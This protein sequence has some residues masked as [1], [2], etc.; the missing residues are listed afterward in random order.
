MAAL[1][2][3][4]PTGCTG[5]RNW[6]NC[7]V[8]MVELP[9]TPTGILGPMSFNTLAPY[10]HG[11]EILFAGRLMQRSRTAFL[12]KA[13]SCQ[14]ALLV[15]EGPGCFLSALL[16]ANPHVQ[17]T[18][19]EH[20]AGM[21]RQARWHLN[22]NRLDEKRVVFV[23]Q[24]A[25]TWSCPST[26]FDLL[27][28]HF[29]LDCFPAEQLDPLVRQL[30]KAATH[31]ASWLLADFQMPPDGWHRYRALTITALLY[32]FF[33]CATGIAASRLTPPDNFLRATGFQLMQ[34]LEWN[35][36]LFHSDLWQRTTC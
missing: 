32:T 7:R 26:Q 27:A 22:R 24:N 11:M 33:R 16:A 30:G 14:H 28:T 3:R 34:R 4:R 2:N 9:T 12:E 13:R 1:W 6:R 25:L 17:V 10:Y 19:V 18:C 31:K 20:S 35:L 23:Q 8:P 36:G 21:I 29:F 5:L 15:G